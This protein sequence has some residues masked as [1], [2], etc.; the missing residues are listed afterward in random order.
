MPGW[1]LKWWGIYLV[2]AWTLQWCSDFETELIGI[3][4]WV[5]ICFEILTLL[6]LV[7]ECVY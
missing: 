2:H 7:P 1:K 3:E 4:M 5:W 6:R